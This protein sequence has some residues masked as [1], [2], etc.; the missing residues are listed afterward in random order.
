MLINPA[1]LG[2]LLERR[3]RRL[4]AKLG[5]PSAGDEL[6][7]LDEELD[8][9]DAP[10]AELDVMAL[11]RDFIVAAI[12]VD[13]PFHRM[14][15]GHGSKIEIFAPDEGRKPR[16]QGLAGRDVAG[17]WPRL[18]QRGTLP[19]LSAAL[20]IVERGGRGDGDLGRGGIW[21]QT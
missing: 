16:E 6:L 10:A 20:V 12:R 13:L 21:A 8:L 4:D 7:G 19:V 2:Q 14:H 15:V 17:A 1:T 5:M 9:A 11:D 3:Q 18:D